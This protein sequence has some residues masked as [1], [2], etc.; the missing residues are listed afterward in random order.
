MTETYD[1]HH[2][3]H[4]RHEP[5]FSGVATV[6]WHQPGFGGHEFREVPGEWLITGDSRLLGKMPAERALLACAMAG[7]AKAR[8][9]AGIQL[10]RPSKRDDRG[11]PMVGAG[12]LF[13]TDFV[14]ERSVGIPYEPRRYVPLGWINNVATRILHN[15]HSGFMDG[16]PP[17][18]LMIDVGAEP[19]IRDSHGYLTFPRL[20]RFWF[21][22]E[23]APDFCK[24]IGRAVEG[25]VVEFCPAVPRR[26]NEG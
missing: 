25:E 2:H 8:Y 3:I 16:T 7:A 21:P 24:A 19:E 13:N 14:S 1:A 12:L 5:D 18:A 17:T 6:S 4:I 20:M 10:S 23:S 26:S 15:R 11:E 9:D 22:I